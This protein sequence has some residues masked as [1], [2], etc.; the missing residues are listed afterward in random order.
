MKKARFILLF[1]LILMLMFP[2]AAYGDMGPKPSV[3]IDFIGLEGKTY[4]VTLLSKVK[5]T[6]PYS[7][8]NDNRRSYDLYREDDKDYDIFLKF[9]EYEDN[10]G[11]YFLQFF[12]D[13]SQTQQFSWTYYPPE[14]FKILIY[15]PDT[16]SFIVSDKSYERY[17]FDSYFIATVSG[18]TVS[19]VKSYDYTNETISLIVRI[20][21]TIASESGVALLFG[22][23]ERRQIR[24]IILVNLITQVMLNVALNII[25]YQ[26]GE[27]AYIMFYILLEILVFIIEAIIY[28]RYLRGQSIKEV[29]K[30]KPGLYAFAGNGLSFILGIYLSYWVPGIF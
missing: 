11:F 8:V 28:N 21:L 5:S 15:F 20:V 27:M 16:D 30:W 26:S 4:Y 7:A 14:E 29:P 6:G 12:K 10:D 13:C 25:N 19:V 2:S 18:S 22:F 17:A 9:A 1:A 24:F 23:R 3:V